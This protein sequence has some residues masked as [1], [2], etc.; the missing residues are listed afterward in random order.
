MFKLRGGTCTTAV[1]DPPEEVIKKTNAILRHGFGKYHLVENNCEDFGIYCKTSLMVRGNSRSAIGTSGQGNSWFRAS[2]KAF[3]VATVASAIM[4]FIERKI[5]KRHTSDDIGTIGTGK[6]W[7]RASLT[8][9][10]VA[11]VTFFVARHGFDIGVRPNAV[12][13]ELKD[14]LLL[15]GRKPE[16]SRPSK[17][18]YCGQCDEV[19]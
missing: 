17:K 6:R 3:V 1:S 14:F 9:I 18:V 16:K 10:L 13:V 8:V 12:R 5:E 15:D 7:F 19:R 2:A 11:A 4:F